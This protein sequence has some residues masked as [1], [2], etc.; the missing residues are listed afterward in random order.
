MTDQELS[1]KI[2]S[3]ASDLAKAIDAVNARGMEVNVTCHGGP[4][5]SVTITNARKYRAAFEAAQTASQ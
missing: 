1:D 2:F 4:D 3:L 5:L